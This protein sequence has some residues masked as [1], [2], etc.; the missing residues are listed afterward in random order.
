MIISQFERKEGRSPIRM[1]ESG[2][3]NLSTQELKETA[4]TDVAL[5]NAGQA[6]EKKEFL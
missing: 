5:T 4:C 2:E 6:N 1:T 3:L